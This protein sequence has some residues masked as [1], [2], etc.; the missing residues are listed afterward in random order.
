M[1]RARARTKKI[2]KTTLK[3]LRVFAVLFLAMFSVIITSWQ[4]VSYMT[5]TSRT[6][7]TLALM[8]DICTAIDNCVQL[9]CHRGCGAGQSSCS[10]SS[11]CSIAPL[12]IADKMEL[13]HNL[14]GVTCRLCSSPIA[15]GRTIKPEIPPPIAII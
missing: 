13:V 11:G 9:N 5:E 1:H 10:M 15:L 8:T 2:S 3:T 4:S 14:R 6:E 12:F 7:D